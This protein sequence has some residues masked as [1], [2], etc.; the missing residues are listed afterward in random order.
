MGVEERLRSKYLYRIFLYLI[1]IIP[2]VW[3]VLV[4]SNNVLAYYGIHSELTSMIAGV[5]LLPWASLL[6]CSLV[7]K[8][9]ICHRLYLY[10]VG[11]AEGINWYDYKIGLSINDFNFLILHT[12]VLIVLIS[13]ITYYHVKYNKRPITLDSR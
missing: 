5:S 9:C 6:L 7:F 12:I 8:F 11:I 3:T 4:F 10:Y 13:I 2:V 1:K